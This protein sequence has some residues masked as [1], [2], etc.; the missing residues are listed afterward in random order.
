[1]LVSSSVVV[2]VVVIGL[3]ISYTSRMALF[4]IRQHVLKAAWSVMGLP[5]AMQ[6]L[7]L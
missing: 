4:L 5:V 7:H 1:M 6:L 2:V 3:V